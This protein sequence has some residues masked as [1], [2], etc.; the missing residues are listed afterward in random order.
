MKLLR[1]TAL[2]AAL[3]TAAIPSLTS[4]AHAGGWH[5]GWGWGGVVATGLAPDGTS[6]GYAP[7]AYS[8]PPHK[9]AAIVNANYDASTV[10]DAHPRA[11]WQPTMSRCHC[12]AI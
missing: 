4:P 3:M 1:T 2:T 7:N 6:F 12:C 5:G 10:T 11:E 8:P 9:G